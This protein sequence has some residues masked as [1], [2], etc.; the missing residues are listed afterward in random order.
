M[1]QERKLSGLDLLAFAIIHGCTQK[2]DGCWYG[3]YERLA[4]RIGG[5]KRGTIMALNHLEEIGMI[6][7]FDAFIDGRQRK[8]IRSLIEGA[9]IAPQGVQE[10]HPEGAKNAPLYNIEKEKENNNKPIFS[11]EV[12]E[13]YAL[14]PTRCPKSNR[15]TDKGIESKKILVRLL[16][17]FSSQEIAAAIRTYIDDCDKTNTFIKNFDTLLHKIEKGEV[18]GDLFQAEPDNQQDAPVYYHSLEEL[19]AA[20]KAKK[21]Q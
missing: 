7:R 10:M 21:K 5:K 17:K 9:N 16:K 13:L 18:S 19:E 14:Y 6:E 20:R 3:G 4:E 1:I 12:E 2:G 8:G 15:G 11:P